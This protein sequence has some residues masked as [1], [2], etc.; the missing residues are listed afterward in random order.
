MPGARRVALFLAMA[1]AAGLAISAAFGVPRER[2]DPGYES[3]VAQFEAVAFGRGGGGPGVLL[4]WR[5]PPFV[6]VMAEQPRLAARHRDD[7]AEV[8]E[9]IGRNTRA[10]SRYD[11]ERMTLAVVLAPRRHYG[12]VLAELEVP[13]R[14]AIL[15]AAAG[16]RCFAQLLGEDGRPGTIAAAV[17]L[18]DSEGS[19]VQRRACIHQELVQSAGLP[20]DACHYRPSLFCNADFPQTTTPADEILLRTLYDPRLRPGMTPAE[21]MPIARRIIREQMS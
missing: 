14:Q 4:R 9:I 20:A 7:F 19:P 1:V 2:G 11:P 8:D 15:R 18:I 5:E 16:S 17:V 13:G 21:A 3:V 12:E 10:P 6:R